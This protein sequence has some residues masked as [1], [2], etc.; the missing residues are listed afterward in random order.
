MLASTF[1]NDGVRL[2]DGMQSSMSLGAS[3]RRWK[4]TSQNRHRPLCSSPTER[5][6]LRRAESTVPLP[7][8]DAPKVRLMLS[9]CR[10]HCEIANA[11]GT[12]SSASNKQSAYLFEC[13]LPSPA[14]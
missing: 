2:Q 3:M 5:S 14:Q 13:T 6:H 11:Q 4:L 12:I 10:T 8:E 9:H 1:E 7:S